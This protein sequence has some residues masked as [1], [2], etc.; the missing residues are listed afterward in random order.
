MDNLILQSSANDITNLKPDITTE[1]IVEIQ[2]KADETS[3]LMVHLADRATREYPN[4]N[5]V[6]ILALPPRLDSLSEISEKANNAL[7]EE[8]KKYN[9]DKIC[10]VEPNIALQGLTK[11]NVFGSKSERND[12]VHMNG[13]HGK[14]A[15]TNSIINALKSSGIANKKKNTKL[16]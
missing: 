15:Y 12:G 3:R 13:K 16:N 2:S 1:N 10:V 14:E 8:V 11:E 6:V 7:K 5:K 9:N 4:I